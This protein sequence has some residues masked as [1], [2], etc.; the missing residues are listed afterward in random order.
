M[1]SG[2]SEIKKIACQLYEEISFQKS[3]AEQNAESRSRALNF[4]F[5]GSPVSCVPSAYFIV[6][7]YFSYL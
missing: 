6:N 1:L 3:S 5:V 2:L 4:A 7:F